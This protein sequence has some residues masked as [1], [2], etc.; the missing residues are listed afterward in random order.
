MRHVRGR[1]GRVA[2]RLLPAADCVEEKDG[3]REEG[4]EAKKPFF[5]L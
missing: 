5:H 1:H 4:E 3:E 2:D